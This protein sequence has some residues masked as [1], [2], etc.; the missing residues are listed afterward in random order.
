MFVA[1]KHFGRVGNLISQ[2]VKEY[3]I[4]ELAAKLVKDRPRGR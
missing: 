2:A 1:K 3:E 4:D